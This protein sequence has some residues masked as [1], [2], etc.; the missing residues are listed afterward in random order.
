MELG[1]NLHFKH[2]MIGKCFT[3]TSN[4]V[5]IR[6]NY[7]QI[8][9]HF[10]HEMIAK[11]LTETSNKVELQVNRV[12]INLHFKHEMIGKMFHRNFEYSGNLN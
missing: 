9:L 4:I 12:R 3:E 11:H 1:I 10:K 5:E 2:E 6:I 8:N 7:V